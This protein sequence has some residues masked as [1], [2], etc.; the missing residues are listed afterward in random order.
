MRDWSREIAEALASAGHHP[1]PAV[2]EELAQHAA[3]TYEAARAEGSSPQDANLR[4]DRLIA[5]WIAQ[6]RG[7]KHRTRLS[8]AVEPPAATASPFT[9]MVHDARYAWRLVWRTPLPALIAALTMALGVGATATL[10]SVVSAVLLKPLPW[11]EPDTL[12]RMRESREGATRTYPATFTNGTYLAWASAP[13]TVEAMAAYRASTV[14]LT[15]AGDP[16]R[17]QVVSTTASLFDIMR[18]VPHRGAVFTAADEPAE[19]VAVLSHA[20]WRRQFG[21]AEDVLGRTL[22]LDG[23]AHAIVG[24][25]PP[26]FAFPDRDTVA[27][28]PM[29]VRPSRTA[30]GGSWI[31]MFTGIARLK[32]GATPEQAAAEATARARSAPDPGLAVIAVFGSKGPAIV[33]A[34]R[35]LDALTA[36]VRPALWVLLAAVALLLITA[37]ANIAS[38]QLA[39]A[40]TRRRELAI[41]ISLGAGSGRLARQ[42][43]LESL[44]LGVVGGLCGIGLSLALHA[45]LPSV[46]PPDFPRVS[47]I[48]IDA[49]VLAFATIVTLAASLAIGLVPAVQARRVAPRG[50]LVED[51]ASTGIAFTRSATARARALIMAGQVAIA[52]LL[53]VG[54]ALLSRTF[55]AM[56]DVD[57]GYDA[58]NVLT[59]RIAS[60]EGLFTPARRLALLERVLERLK[61]H[62][63]VERAASTNV[64]PL[65]GRDAMMALTLPPF[66]GSAETRQVQ[67]GIRV[68]SPGYFEAMGIRAVDGRTF[69]TGDTAGSPRSL[70]VNRAFAERYLGG[71]QPVGLRLPVSLYDKS[72]WT[73]IGIVDN[74][75][76]RASLD[77]PANP[78]MFI[79][80]SEVPEGI[81]YAPVLVVRT[82]G[83]PVRLMADLRRI[84]SGEEPAAT[85]ESIMTMEQRVMG[86]LARPRLYAFVLVG[87]ALFALAI[88]AVGLF[89]V[90]SYSVAQRSKE[91]GVRA[92][93]GARPAQLVGLVL[94]EGLLIT[95]IGLIAGIV[96]AAL[97]A[98]GMASVLFGV[99]PLDPWTFVIVP[100]ALMAVSVMAC[101][102]PARRAATLDPLSVLRAN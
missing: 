4:V 99:A 89:G 62:P 31:Q 7:L 48:T 56:L 8:T 82:A 38:V 77:D 52:C 46:L 94:R 42:L 76:M 2:I 20:F 17:I 67:T 65:M 35:L 74:V 12:V 64:L 22:T 30:E 21:E 33:N 92:A 5:D 1:D 60:P 44:A 96:A 41:R 10:F 13:T 43:I 59:A 25:L 87:F 36:D 18:A 80:H 86:S 102:I 24:I 69:S 66:A 6:G 84:V 53:L 19:H 16:Q 93:L 83:D 85:L 47:D 27:W 37:T 70:I 51:G 79:V 71:T 68:V 26:G 75:R 55:V 90:L 57:R 73:V 78:E 61:A 23:K 58:S 63:A 101:V 54:A 34:E 29:H 45:V 14:T 39:R 3:A 49:R 95:V 15:G 32:P 91:L 88:A 50:S 11:P 9:G 28:V 72:D 98:R 100:V 97:A 40:A 81:A